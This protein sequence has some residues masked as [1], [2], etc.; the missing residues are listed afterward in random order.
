MNP[1]CTWFNFYIP[2]KAF[3]IPPLIPRAKAA[4]KHSNNKQ[5]QR[6]DFYIRTKTV[7]KLCDFIPKLSPFLRKPCQGY[8]PAAMIFFRTEKS[9]SCRSYGIYNEGTVLTKMWVSALTVMNVHFGSRK[10][11]MRMHNR[12]KKHVVIMNC[13]QDS[14]VLGCYTASI[15]SYWFFREKWCLHT[16]ELAVHFCICSMIQ[17]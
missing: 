17:H 10:C 4:T 6:M 15:G 1:L 2:N 16:Q 14:S 13:V 3:G 11:D 7:C 9:N 12:K 5:M 8:A